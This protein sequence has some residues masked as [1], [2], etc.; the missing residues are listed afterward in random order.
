MAMFR[1]RRTRLSSLY[2]RVKPVK[3]SCASVNFLSSNSSTPQAYTPSWTPLSASARSAGMSDPGSPE[4]V[5][6]RPRSTAVAS[7]GPSPFSAATCAPIFPDI[8]GPTCFA[9]AES[10][11]V[12]SSSP[13][14]VP[15]PPTPPSRDTPHTYSESASGSSGQ[16]AR[17]PSNSASTEPGTVRR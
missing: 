17:S 15:P 13:S 10:G 8:A 14:S 7:Q 3:V 1:A 16:A 12:R 5:V 9:E 4:T 6:P 11:N 2:V